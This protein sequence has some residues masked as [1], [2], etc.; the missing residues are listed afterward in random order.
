LADRGLSLDE[1]YHIE[2][3]Y[4]F[5]SGILCGQHL[6]AM[7][8]RPTAIFAGNDEMA[9]GVYR[10]AHEAGLDIP[11]DLSVV[12]FDDSPIVSKVWPPLTSVRLPIRDMGA[13]A[14]RKLLSQ[15]TE[16]P[17]EQDI[18]VSPVMVVRQSTS[19]PAHKNPSR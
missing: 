7:T 17:G 1:R 14:A 5:E 15:I 9:A 3:G 2:G 11:G 12:G 6:L 18:S 10:A 19:I 4:T 16:A 8:P 13:I